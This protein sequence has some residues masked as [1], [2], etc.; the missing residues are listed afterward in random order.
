MD[1]DYEA[2]AAAIHRIATQLGMDDVALAEGMLAIINAKMA[3]AIRTITIQLG[4]DP[5]SSRWSPTAGPARCTRPGW[6]RARHR[7]DPGS[8]EPGDLF[9]MGHAPDRHPP[10]SRRQL[11]PGGGHRDGGRRGRGL[12]RL[13]GEG[14]ALLADEDVSPE[15]V[16]T[17]R[18]A[19][20]RYVGQEYFVTVPVGADIDLEALRRASTTPTGSDTATL[21]RTRL[22]SSSI[23]G[24]PLSVPRRRTH[25]YVPRSDGRDPVIATHNVASTDIASDAGRRPGPHGAGTSFQVP[26]WWRKQAPR[27]SSRPGTSRA[28]TIWATS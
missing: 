15:H 17:E 27:R 3:D 7:G 18:T 19:D 5:D 24:W 13:E 23:C 28:S 21:R 2:A 25:G 11:L 26:W 14:R 4:I 1:L 9:G 16:L 6:P 10:G 22:W 8:V 12:R 20:M